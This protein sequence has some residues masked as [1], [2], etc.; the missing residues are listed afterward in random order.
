MD[1]EGA[2]MI[3]RVES[4][5]ERGEGPVLMREPT[6]DPRESA[7]L[8]D[9]LHA[10]DAGLEGCKSRVPGRIDEVVISVGPALHVLKHRQRMAGKPP[11]T[12]GS[13]SA[14]KVRCAPPKL[15]LHFPVFL[16][17]RCMEEHFYASFEPY[18]SFT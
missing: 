13:L 6:D 12:G 3:D 17:G 9:H 15:P 1:W 4:G 8:I 18:Q 14:T 10:W 2:P 5:I 11:K 16:H 7:L